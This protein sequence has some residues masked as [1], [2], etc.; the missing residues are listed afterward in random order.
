MGSICGAWAS[1]G[2]LVYSIFTFL[3]ILEKQIETEREKKRM[4]ETQRERE[5]KRLNPSQAD[6]TSAFFELP[7]CIPHLFLK[8]DLECQE[9]CK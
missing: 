4:R 1:Q 2:L 5:S 7:Y 6:L 9:G 3:S 8:W